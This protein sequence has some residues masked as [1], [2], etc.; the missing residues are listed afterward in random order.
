MASIR[1]KPKYV[2]QP[3]S[4][5]VKKSIQIF[6]PL[7]GVRRIDCCPA[8]PEKKKIQIKFSLLDGGSPSS[9]GRFLDGGSPSGSGKIYDGGKP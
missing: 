9:S 5:E 3:Q 1:W 8:L 2:I 6:R 4:P 7:F